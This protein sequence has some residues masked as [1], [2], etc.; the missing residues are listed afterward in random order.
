MQLP[1]GCFLYYFLFCLFL[2]SPIFSHQ[3]VL[4]QFSSGDLD[5]LNR[6]GVIPGSYIII[7]YHLLLL[8]YH[9][10]FYFCFFNM[11]DGLFPHSII[12]WHSGV[13]VIWWLLNNLCSEDNRRIIVPGFFCLNRCNCTVWYLIDLF[14]LGSRRYLG[15]CST[16]LDIRG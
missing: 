9:H 16:C 2:L 14:I 12:C 11:D 1:G 7:Q 10:T 15:G 6:I 4:S 3:S 5:A 8:H 13:N